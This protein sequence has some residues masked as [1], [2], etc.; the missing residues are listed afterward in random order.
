[1]GM[2]YKMGIEQ[3]LTQIRIRRSIFNKRPRIRLRSKRPRHPIGIERQYRRL[4]LK[5]VAVYEQTVKDTLMAKLPTFVLVANSLRPDGLRADN[6]VEDLSQLI[7][8]I[9]FVF[10]QRIPNIDRTIESIARQVADYNKDDVSQVIRSVIGV[11]VFAQEPWL[12]DQMQS[13]ISQNKILVKGLEQK[14]TEQLRGIALRGLSSGATAKDIGANIQ[15]QFGITERRAQLIAR[16]EVATFNGELTR[17][18]QTEIGIK[19]YIWRTSMDERVR[20]EHAER[21]GEIFDWDKPPEDGHPGIPI[22][23]RCV[24]EPVLT[25]VLEQI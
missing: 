7:D 18:R 21:E 9:A 19:Q 10:A 17:L 13:F 5:Y 6:W 11:D 16:N 2:L 8:S 24:A 4:L 12:R 20:P 25:N 15:K 1:M 22:N 3:T 14:A 23:C